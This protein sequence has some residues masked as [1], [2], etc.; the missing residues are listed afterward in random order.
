MAN[1]RL[2]ALLYANIHRM[3]D[4]GISLPS[5]Y[6]AMVSITQIQESH[7]KA[8]NCMLFLLFLF[9]LALFFTSQQNDLPTVENAEIIA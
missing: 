5:L 9:V 2:H 7:K 1:P 6:E 8:E 4:F 3:L